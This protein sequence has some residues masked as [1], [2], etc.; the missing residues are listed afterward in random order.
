MNCKECSRGIWR[1]CIDYFK[2]PTLVGC[3]SGLP[4]SHPKMCAE[5]IFSKTYSY[6]KTLGLP[7]TVYLSQ[8]VGEITITYYTYEAAYAQRNE[9]KRKSFATLQG[10]YHNAT[11]MP[12]KEFYDRAI[13]DTEFQQMGTFYY[14]NG[15]YEV[16]IPVFEHL[17]Y[18]DVF[19]YVCWY[20]EGETRS[21]IKL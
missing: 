18:I 19:P 15:E 10:E 11:I 4:I 14:H 21:P 13:Q 8:I 6:A 17:N 3:S 20:K 2:D 7:Y 5:Q 9:P 1:Y 16:E 12:S